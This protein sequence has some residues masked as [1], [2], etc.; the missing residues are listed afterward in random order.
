[1]FIFTMMTNKRLGE[2]LK[3]AFEDGVAVGFELAKLYDGIEYH[4]NALSELSLEK[5][6]RRVHPN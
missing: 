4:I 3:E 5:L 6:K 1:M 2:R